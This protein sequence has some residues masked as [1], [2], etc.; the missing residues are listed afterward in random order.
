MLEAKLR[1]AV[2]SAPR[3]QG[4]IPSVVPGRH[5]RGQALSRP[6]MKRLIQTGFKKGKAARGGDNRRIC[7][8]SINLVPPHVGAVV[9]R[10]SESFQHAF[11]PLFVFGINRSQSA[12]GDSILRACAGLSASSDLE[13]THGFSRRGAGHRHSICEG[14]ARPTCM[15]RKALDPFAAWVKK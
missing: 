15:V 13:C 4:C 7:R 11:A 3:W 9:A 2:G 1:S 6:R 14:R 10:R 12:P 5:A 8:G